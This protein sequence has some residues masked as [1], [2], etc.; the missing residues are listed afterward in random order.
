MVGT[1]LSMVWRE[2]LEAIVFVLMSTAID[3]SPGYASEPP[4]PQ[5][6]SRTEAPREEMP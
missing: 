1:L 6:L 3:V 4:A 2:G 5:V